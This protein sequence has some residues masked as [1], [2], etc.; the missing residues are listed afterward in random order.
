MKS[1]SRILAA[2]LAVVLMGV[3]VSGC[4][5]NTVATV[6]GQAITKQDLQA[7]FDAVKSQY[8]QLLQGT[9]STARVDQLKKQLL[10]SMVDQVLVAQ[11]AK[12]MGVEVTDADVAKQ[13]D[14]IR[15]QFPTDA[16]YQE[17]LKKFGTTEAKLKE[18]IKQQLLV[19]AVTAKLAK[20]SNVSDAEI[21][22]YYDKNKAMFQETAGKRVSHI[23]VKD[24]ATADKI[25]AQ[26]AGGANFATLAKQY[27]IDKA[28]ASAGGDLGW[29][30]SAYVPE[31]QAAVNKLTKIGQLSP[32][33]KSTYG[34]HIIK[35][36]QQRGARLKPLAEVKEQIK[37][38]IAQQT[39]ADSYQKFIADLR[40]KF[41]DKIKIDT[42]VLA[43]ITA[44]STASK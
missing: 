32:V 41:K 13:F 11:A 3:V 43:S 20:T 9:D 15:K 24:K 39:Q 1:V 29:P 27:S 31:F 10:D 36:E 18:Q 42:A 17:A 14:Q 7:Q 16:A 23:L 35:L 6:N 40:K 12:D 30:T 2:A 5:N 38:I 44:S 22:A 21:K 25:N 37:Q 4:T 34:Y 26:L 19:Q 33:V 28:S 8:P